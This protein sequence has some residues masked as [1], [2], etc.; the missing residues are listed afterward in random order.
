MLVQRNL[1]LS[2]NFSTNKFCAD[3]SN[4]IVLLL[5]KMK[6]KTLYI[7]HKMHAIRLKNKTLLKDSLF[8]F[9]TSKNPKKPYVQI[10]RI[11]ISKI[12]P[13]I[14]TKLTKTYDSFFIWFF[15][16]WSFSTS[17]LAFKY[18]LKFIWKYSIFRILGNKPERYWWRKRELKIPRNMKDIGC[19]QAPFLPVISQVKKTSPNPRSGIGLCRE[20]IM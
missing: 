6:I 1:I 7:L 17:F 19:T 3:S 2:S 18:L 9:R 10:K 12:K 11:L 13:N 8:F 20:K 15:K 4:F 14:E 5:G 16:P